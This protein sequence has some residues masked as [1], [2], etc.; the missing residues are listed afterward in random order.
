MP[1]PVGLSNAHS[2]TH[3]FTIE[4]TVMSAPSDYGTTA[5]LEKRVI[6]GAGM[7][8]YSFFDRQAEEPEVCAYASYP[9]RKVMITTVSQ[10]FI[11]PGILVT[12]AMAA[13][14]AI[15]WSVEMGVAFGGAL[16]VL[17]S[18]AVE[19]ISEKRASKWTIRS[20]VVAGSF[21]WL[22]SLAVVVLVFRVI[23]RYKTEGLVF[24]IIL[25]FL[26][27]LEM[28]ITSVQVHAGSVYIW[29]CET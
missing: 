19:Y 25:M 24:N 28:V 5:E 7:D 9:S 2:P 12:Q 15:G 17:L 1:I 11:S 13:A 21:A 18:G 27:V 10:F 22:Y 20:S 8:R 23:E 29:N 26:G 4:G 6:I 14:T 16:V 3:A